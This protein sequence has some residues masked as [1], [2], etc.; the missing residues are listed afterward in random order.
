MFSFITNYF[1]GEKLNR[2]LV[3][4]LIESIS[5]NPNYDELKETFEK[6]LPNIPLDN[7]YSVDEYNVLFSEFEH[8]QINNF[9]N[10]LCS[11]IELSLIHI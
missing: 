7:Y 5:K 3:T 10:N 8:E 9:S 2:E 1:R 6:L 4:P 11:L